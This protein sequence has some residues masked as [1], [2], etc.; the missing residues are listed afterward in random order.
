VPRH[1]AGAASLSYCWPRTSLGQAIAPSVPFDL[2]F[3]RSLGDPPEHP[4]ET[5]AHVRASRSPN[6]ETALAACF[7][8]S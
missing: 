3:L 4:C 7:S 2:I 5:R 6:G 8:I 1:S